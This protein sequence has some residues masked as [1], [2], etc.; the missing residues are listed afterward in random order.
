MNSILYCI[1]KHISNLGYVILNLA[2]Y[3]QVWYLEYWIWNDLQQKALFSCGDAPS[4]ES[5][6]R[7]PIWNVG[8]QPIPMVF[9]R[10][11]CLS[12]GQG[13]GRRVFLK[14]PLKPNIFSEYWILN[15]LSRALATLV[16]LIFRILIWN[17][18]HQPIPMV[19][20]C[21]PCL[22][23]GQGKGRRVFLK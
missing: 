20:F 5:I 4:G 8:H 15:S 23:S 17:F 19:F 10:R 22:S 12:S 18:G 13:K 21:R 6:F 9:F 1:L 11:P 3:L 14:Q 7:I 2:N 16:A